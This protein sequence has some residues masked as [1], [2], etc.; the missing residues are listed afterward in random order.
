M[1]LNR[2]EHL[3]GNNLFTFA[4]VLAFTTD[5]SAGLHPSLTLL[6]VTG[7]FRV[8]SANG[9]FTADRTDI[10]K[11]T[12]S[13]SGGEQPQGIAAARRRAG[14]RLAIAPLGTTISPLGATIFAPGVETNSSLLST[15][16]IQSGASAPDRALIELDRQRILQLQARSQN[17]VV[18]P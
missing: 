13:L 16:I 1:R 10:H 17:L 3:T 8:T 9:D 6:P 2:S 18:G 5:L 15:T 7:G 14:A 12:L 11:V 4:D